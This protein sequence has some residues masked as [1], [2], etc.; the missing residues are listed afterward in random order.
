MVA[1]MIL[2]E[3]EK[4]E[5]ENRFEEHVG[6]MIRLG[7]SFGRGVPE[8]AKSADLL[9]HIHFNLARLTSDLREEKIV[10][11]G[12]EESRKEFIKESGECE[13]ELKQIARRVYAKYGVT[14]VG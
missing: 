9:L 7:S 14:D 1:G 2:S 12:D 4:V 6:Q 3:E 13:G 11:R 10:K 8:S 5:I